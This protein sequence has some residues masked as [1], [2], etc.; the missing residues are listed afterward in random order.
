MKAKI[1][2]ILWQRS[3]FFPFL[4]HIN[5]YPSCYFSRDSLRGGSTPNWKSLLWEELENHLCQIQSLF[6]RNSSTEI[7]Q[8]FGLFISLFVSI[9]SH[10]RQRLYMMDR[11]TYGE[12][13]SR[14]ALCYRQSCHLLPQ[15]LFS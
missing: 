1:N 13:E 3:T 14:V 5:H 15:G 2:I 10:S 9:D 7:E 4:C 11:K 12:M 6:Q 8:L